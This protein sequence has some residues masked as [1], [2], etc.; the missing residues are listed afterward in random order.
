MST[1][2]LLRGLTRESR[3]WGEFPML[4]EAQLGPVQ[5]VTLDLPGNG[6]RHAQA[7]PTRVVDMAE[8]CRA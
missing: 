1:W 2:V 7:S 8:S 3:H 4:L 5:V 6:Q